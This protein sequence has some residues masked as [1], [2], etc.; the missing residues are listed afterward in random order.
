MFEEGIV[1][2]LGDK[3]R[4]I[5]M[6]SHLDL[7]QF[8]DEIIIMDKGKIAY[9]GSYKDVMRNDEYLHLLPLPD[10]DESK[11]EEEESENDK[12]ALQ[13]KKKNEFTASKMKLKQKEEDQEKGKLTTKE[14][15]GIG[16]IKWSVYSRYFS[17]SANMFNHKNMEVVRASNE[18]KDQKHLYRVYH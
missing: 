8:M 6:N 15:R 5:V 3:T 12:K 14:D 18:E 16:S 13:N 10:E 2:L 4:V 9:K 7:L 11:E 17:N 1:D